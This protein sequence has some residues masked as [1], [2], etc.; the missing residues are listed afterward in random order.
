[1]PARTD[2]ILT[3]FWLALAVPWTLAACL[4]LGALVGTGRWVPGPPRSV[5]P[6]LDFVDGSSP[7]RAPAERGVQR[8]RACPSHERR[9]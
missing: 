3:R 8:Q 5:P 2:R 6:L 7:C 1:M 9:R 4:Q